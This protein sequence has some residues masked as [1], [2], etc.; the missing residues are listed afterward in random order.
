MPK[1]SSAPPGLWL[2]T[3]GRHD[4]DGSV[5][6]VSRVG[7]G[8]RYGGYR[9]VAVQRAFLEHALQHAS[10]PSQAAWLILLRSEFSATTQFCQTT[11]H[12]LSLHPPTI[13]SIPIYHGDGC[14]SQRL[15]I[16]SVEQRTAPGDVH[17]FSPTSRSAQCP[18]MLRPL[19][20]RGAPP[21]LPALTG[22]RPCLP[23][24]G[25]RHSP[26]PCG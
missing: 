18:R 21:T 22:V 6:A 14:K 25:Q 17:L 26:Q 13:I 20:V 3:H 9:P 2:D 15:E 23:K 19:L 1:S 16:M 4:S 5:E 7:Y 24:P 11:T 12:H 8:W 10:T